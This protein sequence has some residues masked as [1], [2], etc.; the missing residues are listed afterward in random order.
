MQEN[1]RDGEGVV[2]LSVAD[3]GHGA[4][5]ADAL[6]PEGFAVASE[7]VQQ[8]AV[9]VQQPDSQQRIAGQ[10]HEIP[11]VDEGGV[12]E[13]EIDA[14][15]LR[16]SRLDRGSF[17]MPEDLHQGEQGGEAHFVKF[18]RDAGLELVETH[19]PPAFLHHVARHG[20]LDAEEPVAFAILSRPRLEE[21]GQ[22]C[23]LRRVGMGQH[24]LEKL[25]Q[26]RDMNSVTSLKTGS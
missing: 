11:V 3:E 23:N 5:D 10:V 18:A 25:H 17:R 7:L 13:V 8:R 14:R 12:G 6:L 19:L 21:A 2:Q 15:F 4:D 16:H 26:N 9:L 20:H 22:A 1:V 24:F